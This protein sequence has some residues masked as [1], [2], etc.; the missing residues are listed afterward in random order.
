MPLSMYAAIVTFWLSFHAIHCCR[1]SEL[2]VNKTDVSFP[3][4]SAWMVPSGIIEICPLG[5]GI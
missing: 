5:G 4:V 3:P 2:K 1:L